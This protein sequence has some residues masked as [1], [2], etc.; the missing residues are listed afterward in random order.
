MVGYSRI[1]YAAALDGNFFSVFAKVHPTKNFPHVSL[2]W[3]GAAAFVFSLLFR[4]ADVIR[5]ILAMRI[6]VQF[7]GGAVGVM[8]LRKALG[9]DKIPFKMWFYP[10]PAIIAI[11]LWIAIMLS[12]GMAFALPG[13][14][15]TVLGIVVFLIRAKTQKQWPFNA[16]VQ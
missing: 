13:I 3:L 9:A 11:V 16:P 1:P 2:L 14:G 5:A 15:M 8:L 7:I 6:I 12:T 10:L 4:M